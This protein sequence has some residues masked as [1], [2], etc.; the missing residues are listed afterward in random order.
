MSI[1]GYQSMMM[2]ED[3]KM[4]YYLNVG[5][6]TSVEA[7]KNT[8]PMI[9]TIE[10]ASLFMKMKDGEFV[11]SRRGFWRHGKSWCFSFSPS[12]GIFELH[13]LEKDENFFATFT[14]EIDG[15]IFKSEKRQFD[16]GMVWGFEGMTQLD[17]ESFIKANAWKFTITISP[18]K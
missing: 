1:Q 12:K 3:S 17:V 14:M 7:M 13:V 8:N 6:R 4:D 10:N 18:T 15:H 16:R 2:D 9:W 11:N 5:R